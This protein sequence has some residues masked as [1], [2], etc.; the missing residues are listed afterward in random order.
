MSRA[1]NGEE[2]LDILRLGKGIHVK[3]LREI[4]PFSKNRI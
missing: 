3:T 4:R 2:V 1:Q